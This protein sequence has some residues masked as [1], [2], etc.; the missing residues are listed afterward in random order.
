M[1][2]IDLDSIQDAVYDLAGGSN[3]AMPTLQAARVWRWDQRS[4]L[5]KLLIVR[6]SR[7]NNDFLTAT[8]VCIAGL[9]QMCVA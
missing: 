4:G 1:K 7:M 6:E 8:C 3:S 2:D 5:R 9:V